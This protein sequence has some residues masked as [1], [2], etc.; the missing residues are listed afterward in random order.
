VRSQYR[1]GEIKGEGCTSEN[2]CSEKEKQEG[3]KKEKGKKK[4]MGVEKRGERRTTYPFP[5]GGGKNVNRGCIRVVRVK[6]W[7][8]WRPGIHTTGS[9]NIRRET[10]MKNGGNRGSSG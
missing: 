10:E 9:K 6:S 2:S 1:K 5:G 4:G 8:W 3:K 7:N